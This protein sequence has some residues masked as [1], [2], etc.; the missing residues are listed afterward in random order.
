MSEHSP[1]LANGDE[2]LYSGGSND[3][4]FYMGVDKRS[5]LDTGEAGLSTVEASRRLKVFGSNE[6]ESKE[7]SKWIK[8]A[9][10]F[11]GPMPIMIWLAIL[12]EAITRDWPDFLVLLF[13]QL[14][15]GTVGWYEELKAGNAVAALK[16]SLKPEA[17][18]I[19][20][21][22]H[23]TINAALLVPGD[24]ITLSSG[25]AVPADCDLCEGHPVQIDQAALTG[26]SF[27]VTMT[28]GDN[29]KMGSTVVRG[30]VEAVVSAT[31]GQTFFGKTAS[32]ISSVD[33]VSH[34]Q[35]ILLRITM[36]LMAISFVLV[37]FCLGYLIYNGEDFLEAIA[38]CV[39]LLVASIPIAMQVV[40]TST[41]AL[42]SR[43]LAEEKVIVTQL[44]SIET[45]SGMNMLCSDKTGTLTRNKMELQDDLPIFHPTATREEVL[46]TAALAA[47]WKEPPKDALDTLVLNAIDLRPLDKYTMMD[48]APFDP[49]VKRTE[50][51][52]RGPDGKVFKVTKGAPQIILALAHNVTEIQE[53]VE[54]KVLDLAKRGIRSLAVG[55]TSEEEAEGGWVFLGI[56][57]FLDPPRHDTKRTIEL[58]H[59]NG[60]GVKMI[61]GDQAAIAVETCRML[62]MGT[63]ILGTDVLPTANVQDGLS[64]TLGSDYGAIV[65]SADGFAQVFPEHKFLIVEVLRQRG[66]VCGMTGD[67]VNDAPALKKAD[68]GIAVEGSTDAARAAADIVL[69]QPGLSVIINAIT[70]SRKIF[71]RMRNYVTYRI[72]CTI[73]LLMFFFI[74]VLLIHPD[75]CRFQHFIPHIGDCPLN[76]NESTESV[77]PYFKL[78]V[79]ALVLITIL[80][81][82]TII[83]IA[84]DNVVPSKRPESWNLPRIYWV[85]TTLGLIAVASSLLLLFWGL[86]SWNKNG[87]LAYFGLG[88]L[89]Y[90]QVMMM[91]YLKISL[92]DFMT[93][94]TARTDGLFF[95][96]APGHLLAVAACF[97][98]FVSTLLAVYWPFTEMAAISF[99]LAIFVWIYCVGWFFVQDLGKVLLT[100]A[101]EHFDQMNVFERKVSS[102]KYVKHEAQRQNRIRMGSTLLNNDSFMH[103]SFVAGRPVGGSFV[104][105]SMTL[106][107]A[108]N[109]LVRIEAEVK[110]I[111]AIIQNASSSAKV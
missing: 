105:R 62:G 58:A 93:V 45:L 2:Q 84:Y 69:T 88:D 92:S 8:L 20:D 23:Q 74:S 91:M 94:F 15:N 98:T 16:A 21:G 87:I 18:V 48:H 46:V 90:D 41:M 31:G 66:W 73:Q 50:S 25:A 83:S 85:A 27:P 40:C 60:I 49:S 104:E 5:L 10:Q 110:V 75:S 72:A 12:V 24:R 55:R 6:L 38:F 103:G 82:G 53:D 109:R 34:F 42:G 33:E 17:Q 14:L 26:E 1:L 80:N 96:R 37:G 59:Q 13:L 102:K 63:T 51:T 68:V 52:I 97:A 79:I 76:T 30:E 95:T 86:D 22:V 44:Q 106:E 36:F 56:M 78:P 77:D 9:E 70:L 101:L 32:L 100:F 67:G 39:V 43:K 57:T 71:Q 89:P 47:K 28:A 65:E 19:R 99:R 108:M 11:W 35:K 111:R 64:M 29:A 7:K 61:T 54:A 81:D 107:Q 4:R 3:D